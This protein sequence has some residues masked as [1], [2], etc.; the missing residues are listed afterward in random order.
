MDT[1]DVTTKKAADKKNYL[2]GETITYTVTVNNDGPS[3]ALSPTV[4]DTVLIKVLNP[5]FSV[6]D[7]ASWQ[8]WTGTT[9]LANLPANASAKLLIRGTVARS[10]ADTLPNSATTSTPT[11]NREGRDNTTTGRTVD[12]PLN[13]NPLIIDTADITTEKVSDKKD[14]F[15]GEPILYTGTVTNRGPS[16][17]KTPTITDIVPSQVEDLRYSVNSGPA[18]TWTGTVILPDLPADSVTAIRVMGR[19]KA[20]ATGSLANSAT[21]TTP[22]LNKEGK[23][24]ITTGTVRDPAVIPTADVSATKIADKT[25]AKPGDD[26]TYTV[27]VFNSGPE[28]ARVLTVTDVLPAGYIYPRFSLNNGETWVELRGSI[29]LPDLFAY[30]RTS[31]LIRATIPKNAMGG[32][33]SNTAFINTVTPRPDG[34]ITPIA[35]TAPPIRVELPT[36]EVFKPICCAP[37]CDCPGKD[38]CR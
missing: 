33:P 24:N 35:A 36:M 21:T 19:V 25:F 37:E 6:N 2:P 34:S 31:V 14:Y 4:R 8:P 12:D 18:A 30:T 9:T 32:I 3:T 38:K 16:A 10:A 20:G 29:P 23:N 13:G 5:Q 27:T 22:T 17:A 15:P 1:A 26:I 28:A 7:G 11:L